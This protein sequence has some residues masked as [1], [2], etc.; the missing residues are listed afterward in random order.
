MY[1][2]RSDRR[3]RGLPRRAWMYELWSK[4]GNPIFPYGNTWMKSPWWDEY[5]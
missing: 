4:F 5:E 3:H 1:R 2:H